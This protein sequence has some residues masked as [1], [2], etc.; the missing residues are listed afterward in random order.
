[1]SEI[2]PEFADAEEEVE[3]LK[4]YLESANEEIEALRDLIKLAVKDLRMRGS[5]EG[6]IE[7]SGFI[8]TQLNDVADKI[9]LD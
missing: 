5:E 1:M 7:I 4:G 9:K 3:F 2:I 8:W 6:V